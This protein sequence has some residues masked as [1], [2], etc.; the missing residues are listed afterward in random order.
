MV[1]VVTFHGLAWRILNNFGRFYGHPHPVRVQS[2]AEAGLSV[3]FPGITYNDLVPAAIALLQVP[4]IADY[5][6]RRYGTVICD[7]R[8]GTVICDEFQD[9]SEAEWEFIQT[10][11][12]ASQRILLG[13]P[14]Q[15]IYAGMKSIDP[16]V[17]VAEAAALPGAVYLNL[18]ALSYRDPSGVLPAAALA[19]MERRFD[20]PAIAHAIS[21]GRIVLRAPSH[22][23]LVLV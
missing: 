23:G 15:C 6:E 9:T 22:R 8:Y 10:V 13:D 18:P 16:H 5:Y 20:D 17:R 7:R 12:P 4:T 3:A 1:D 14:N 11:A 19:A 2:A 21:T